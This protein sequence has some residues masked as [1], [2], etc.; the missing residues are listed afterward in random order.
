MAGE[1]LDIDWDAIASVHYDLPHI[2]KL[3]ETFL[4]RDFTPIPETTYVVYSRSTRIP[5]ARC[6]RSSS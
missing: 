1:H 6:S 5:T 4:K 2:R 3:M